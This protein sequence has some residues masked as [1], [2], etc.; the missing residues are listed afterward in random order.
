VTKVNRISTSG[1]G[2]TYI[3]GSY[4][5]DDDGR[6]MRPDESIVRGVPVGN[7]DC[8]ASLPW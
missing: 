1:T 3:I 5:I 8:D 2:L 4:I 6:C 7:E